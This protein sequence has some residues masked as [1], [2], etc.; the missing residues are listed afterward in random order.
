MTH[1]SGPGL[2]APGARGGSGRGRRPR[3]P[4]LDGANTHRGDPAGAGRL[5]LG[6]AGPGRGGSYSSRSPSATCSVPAPACR[7]RRRRRTRHSCPPWRRCPAGGRS[8]RPGGRQT[9]TAAG[10]TGPA[11]RFQFA[12]LAGAADAH[13]QGLGVAAGPVQDLG[14]QL[15][16]QAR[17]L[18]AA[19]EG[20]RVLRVVVDRQPLVVGALE[21]HVRVGRALLGPEVAGLR[22]AVLRGGR[23]GQSHQPCC[24]AG[25]AG[26]ELTGLPQVRY[27]MFCPSQLLRTGTQAE[28]V[29][30]CAPLWTEAA[31]HQPKPR[32]L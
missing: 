29:A 30:D 13:V 12:H 4:C 27:L 3:C 16:H 19:P 7:W 24:G 20:A 25:A 32:L 11:S 2:S 18:G 8:R 5:I 15:H 28:R 31:R 14:R 6:R 22:G 1:T 17:V 21:G 23:R 10:R 9:L 26:A